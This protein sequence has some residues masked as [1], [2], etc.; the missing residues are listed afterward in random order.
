MQKILPIAII[1]IVLGLVATMA[2]VILIYVITFT[3]NN[4]KDSTNKDGYDYIHEVTYDQSYTRDS[5]PVTIN[6][7]QDINKNNIE[8]IYKEQFVAFTIVDNIVSFEATA[9]GTYDIAIKDEIMDVTINNI[10]IE[11][12][13]LLSVYNRD[14]YLKLNMQDEYT[15]LDYEESYLIYQEKTY[16]ITKE[17]TVIGEFEGYISIVLVT[18]KGQTITYSIELK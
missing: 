2:I 15:Q 7:Y 9:N 16:Q 3:G 8:I 12:P 11:I 18:N 4:T 14:Q 13:E 1:K 17:N 5:V 10:D 6:L